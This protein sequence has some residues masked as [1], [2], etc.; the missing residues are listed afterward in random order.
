[1]IYNFLCNPVDVQILPVVYLQLKLYYFYLYQEFILYT[2][3]GLLFVC[4]IRKYLLYYEVFWRC[5]KEIGWVCTQPHY[6][7]L[8][9]EANKIKRKEWC[10]RQIDNK[11]QF[12]DVIVTDECTVQLDHHGRLCFRKEKEVRALKQRPKH[13]AKVHLWVGFQQEVQLDLLCSL[14]TWMQQGMEKS[15]RQD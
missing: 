14:E 13:P 15:S 12:E 4:I 2:Y 8:I 9:T 3:Y 1:M 11:E 10:Q 7:Q 6:C 5:R